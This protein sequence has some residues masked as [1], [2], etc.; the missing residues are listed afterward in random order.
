MFWDIVQVLFN[1]F[2]TAI[3]TSFLLLVFTLTSSPYNSRQSATVLRAPNKS[4]RKDSF[5]LMPFDDGNVANAENGDER[6]SDDKND[7]KGRKIN[8]KAI[9]SM[10]N[11]A[12]YKVN[13]KKKRKYKIRKQLRNS[14]RMFFTWLY[15]IPVFFASSFICNFFQLLARIS[16]PL[17]NY[18]TRMWLSSWFAAR[19]F[20]VSVFAFEMW[21]NVTYRIHSYVLSQFRN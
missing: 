5:G 8:Q 10:N 4:P 2:V 17:F 9:D 15:I 12:N 7:I 13:S 20:P 6:K 18:R 3:W 19:W 14:F 16:H 11:D 1:V 21:P